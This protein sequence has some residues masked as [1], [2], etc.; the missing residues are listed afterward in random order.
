VA[1]FIYGHASRKTVLST[2]LSEHKHVS[3]EV[4]LT[5]RKG[6]IR[7]LIIDSSPLYDLEGQLI[8][9][10]CIYRNVIELRDLNVSEPPSRS[11]C[12]NSLPG[13]DLT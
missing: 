10:L 12:I 5:S 2:S 11:A 3:K 7:K 9:A 1:H 8:G 13:Q 4:E 6:R